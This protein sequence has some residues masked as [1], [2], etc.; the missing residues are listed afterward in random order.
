MANTNNTCL[1]G[2]NYDARHA[3]CLSCV[4]QLGHCKAKT[5]RRTVAIDHQ[6]WTSG[7]ILVTTK[8]LLSMN[9]WHGKKPHVY[10][11]YKRE[12]SKILTGTWALWGKA[13]GKRELKVRSY[14]RHEGHLIKDADNRIG[15]IK[16][17]KDILVSNGVLLDDTDKLV[18]FTVEQFVGEPRTELEVSNELGT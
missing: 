14:V 15:A 11:S 8:P 12:W 9:S 17:L 16:P 10:L 3:T 5:P 18:T 4:R 13:T 6:W 1:R 7:D 2:Y